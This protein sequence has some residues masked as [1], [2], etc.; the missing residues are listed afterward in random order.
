MHSAPP[1]TLTVAS[2][3]HFAYLSGNTALFDPRATRTGLTTTLAVKN[4]E[5]AQVGSLT[6]KGEGTPKNK[7]ALHKDGLKDVL[8]TIAT[9]TLANVSDVLVTDNEKELFNTDA[10]RIALANAVETRFK[11]LYSA[12]VEGLEYVGSDGANTINLKWLTDP[13]QCLFGHSQVVAR[14]DG[15]DDINKMTTAVT[16]RNNYNVS[17]RNFR[18]AQSIN[19]DFDT[20]VYVYVDGALEC[21]FSD[22]F[23]YEL[24]S[25]QYANA[26]AKTAAHEAGHTLGLVHT[27]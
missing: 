10:E 5:G 6:M 1:P 19:Q 13:G 24:T 2:A 20:N 3:T 15:V 12:F 9:G 22:T 26:L 4:P 21:P 14:D 7:I 27:A 16:N 18:L 17:E 25:Q 11:S 8:S 23:P